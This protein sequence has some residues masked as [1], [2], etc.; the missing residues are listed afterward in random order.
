MKRGIKNISESDLY[1]SFLNQFQCAAY[2]YML[3]R[4][5]N[6]SPDGTAK[7]HRNGID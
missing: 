2:C 5:V 4:V 6:T 3:R 1:L 7:S